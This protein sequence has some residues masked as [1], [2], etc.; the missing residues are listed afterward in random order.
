M[1]LTGIGYTGICYRNKTEFTSVI[2]KEMPEVDVLTLS[3]FNLSLTVYLYCL[4]DGHHG[5]SD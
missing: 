3:F 1:V 5:L 4:K 2:K